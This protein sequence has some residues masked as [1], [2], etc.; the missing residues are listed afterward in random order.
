[1][2]GTA[3]IGTPADLVSDDDRSVA[4]DAS[5]ALARL[6]SNRS[7][8]VEARSDNCDSQT[9]V[10]PAS[11]VRL[12]TDMLTH[13]A[14]GH[15]VAVIPEDAELTTQQAADLLNVSRP[16]LVG[17]LEK[18]EIPFRLVGRHRRIRFQDMVA[19]REVM[20]KRRKAAIDAMVAQAQELGFGY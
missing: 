4:R 19:F 3:L 5:R 8:H 6:A 12:L 2:M 16:F 13:L 11:A 18:N 15:A 9:F 17:L 20:Q 7:V 10:L 14:N 1:M